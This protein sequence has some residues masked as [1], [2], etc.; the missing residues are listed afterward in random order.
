MDC[1]PKI[2]PV[3]L[4]LPALRRYTRTTLCFLLKNKLQTQLYFWVELSDTYGHDRPLNVLLANQHL[5][6]DTSHVE[7]HRDP[8][9]TF[10]IELSAAISALQLYDIWSH[11]TWDNLSPSCIGSSP[12]L[13][14]VAELSSESEPTS[15]HPGTVEPLQGL[16]WK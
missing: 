14:L 13:T 2:N 15:F 10:H 3:T 12:K 9:S 4:L 7:S 1:Y 16:H 6:I 8:V 11:L 5:F